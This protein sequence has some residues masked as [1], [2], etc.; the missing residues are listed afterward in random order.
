MATG[1]GAVTAVYDEPDGG[2]GAW[3]KL[4]ATA[5]AAYF[6]SGCND[7]YAAPLAIGPLQTV[8]NVGCN[9]FTN[10]GLVVDSSSIY[11]YMGA[12]P[13]G[14]IS[15]AVLWRVHLVD[16][17]LDVIDA[18]YDGESALAIDAA[19][20]YW[21]AGDTIKAM[22]LGG[23]ATSAPV[24]SLGGSHTSVGPLRVDA[25]SLF[26]AIDNS[27]AGGGGTLAEAPV[28]GGPPLVLWSSSHYVTDFAMDAQ[29]VYFTDTDDGTIL[30]V[31]R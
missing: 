24:A 25:R 18:N 23:G 17:T 31:A 6:G 1:G 13:P 11:A 19:Q 9:A 8:F 14:Q 2:P 27:G 4:T 12:I 29:Y 21:I 30:R 3:A 15:G 7:L 26:W 10:L 20:I 22:P 16:G 5:A 28:G